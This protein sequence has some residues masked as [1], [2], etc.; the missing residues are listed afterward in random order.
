MP[1][2]PTPCQSGMSVA[3]VLV[4]THALLLFVLAAL[5]CSARRRLF[6]LKLGSD[7][8]TTV[9]CHLGCH[10]CGGEATVAEAPAHRDGAR[11]LTSIFRVCDRCALWRR[12]TWR[13][14]LFVGLSHLAV[15]FWVPGLP[16]V[17]VIV[18]AL[19]SLA[20]DVALIGVAIVLLKRATGQQQQLQQRISDGNSNDVEADA[21]DCAD[22]DALPACVRA[23]LLDDERVCAV[24]ARDASVL[25]SVSATSARVQHKV[26]AVLLVLG[27]AQLAF[28]LVGLVL[29]SSESLKWLMLTLF[30]VPLALYLTAHALFDAS[31]TEFVVA[32]NL[33]VVVVERPLWARFLTARSLW[34]ADAPRCLASLRAQ[35]ADDALRYCNC[36]ATAPPSFRC[37]CRRARSRVERVNM[38]ATRSSGDSDDDNDSSAVELHDLTEVSSSSLWH[39]D[40]VGIQFDSVVEPR[41]DDN[42]D[43][44]LVRF[45]MLRIEGVDNLGAVARAIVEQRGGDTDDQVRFAKRIDSVE[46]ERASLASLFNVKFVMPALLLAA[47]LVVTMILLAFYSWHIIAVPLLLS[48]A[49]VFPIAIGTFG[50]LLR[51]NWI[52]TQRILFG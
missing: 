6:S 29:P 26:V 27:G 49:V 42:D 1:L 19:V 9:L 38:A 46:E 50:M 17:V 14:E 32:T 15:L 8:D 35:L 30:Y 16:S 40:V 7:R 5:V 20:C 45:G 4:F 41:D 2:A 31:V 3:T 22:A 44:S 51:I 10:Y 39:R 47:L 48:C 33:R 52:G 24:A 23:R 34:L 12:L 37:C 36:S 43:D 21:D 11:N 13:A 28:V 18:V 25:G